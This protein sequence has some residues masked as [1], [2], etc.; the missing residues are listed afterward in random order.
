MF[1]NQH[2]SNSFVHPQFTNCLNLSDIFPT[3][4][5]SEQVASNDETKDKSYKLFRVHTFF[6]YHVLWFTPSFETPWND[7]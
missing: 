7:I 1:N 3:N 5:Q 4:K 2:W 6:I